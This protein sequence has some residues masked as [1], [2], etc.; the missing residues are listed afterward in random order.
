M[1]CPGFEEA[2]ILLIRVSRNR[3]RCRLDEERGELH[4]RVSLAEL[5]GIGEGFCHP[6]EVL[7]FNLSE[8]VCPWQVGPLCLLCICITKTQSAPLTWS[9]L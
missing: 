2:L 1:R 9:H 5:A 6:L 3:G 8:G 4:G 7:I